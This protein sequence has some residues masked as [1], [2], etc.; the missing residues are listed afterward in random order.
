MATL[1][2]TGAFTSFLL[3]W[4]CSSF[5]PAAYS[6][7][8]SKSTPS[9][10]RRRLLSSYVN[11]YV[12]T[13]VL[14]KY[15]LTYPSYFLILF[16][17]SKYI[18]WYFWIIYIQYIQCVEVAV[19][20]NESD[21]DGCSAVHWFLDWTPCCFPIGFKFCPF[22]TKVCTFHLLHYSKYFSVHPNWNKNLDSG[23]CNGI[24]EKGRNPVQNLSSPHWHCGRN[25]NVAR[26]FIL[27]ALTNNKRARVFLLK[28]KSRKL[29]LKV[30]SRNWERSQKPR[31][32]QQPNQ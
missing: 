3:Q 6:A 25:V 12:L 16:N 26:R 10:I 5:P 20:Y 4:R 2:G 14:T 17:I 28:I 18:S 29:K 19:T 32:C 15:T 31:W 8:H 24:W 23:Q 7:V 22:S 13:Y 21:C 27:S 11:A 30:Q 9:Y 1:V